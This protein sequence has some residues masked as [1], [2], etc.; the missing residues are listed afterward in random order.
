MVRSDFNQRKKISKGKYASSEFSIQS[1]AKSLKELYYLSIFLISQ[2]V[3]FN[4][5]I[6]TFMCKAF[7]SL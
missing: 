2:N 1:F 5:A 7:T 6:C 4:F 3:Q